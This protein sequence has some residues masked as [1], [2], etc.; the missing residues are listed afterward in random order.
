[1]VY[2]V[3]LLIMFCHSYVQ[4]FS[5]STGR[6]SPVWAIIDNLKKGFSFHVTKPFLI[7]ETRYYQAT[8]LGLPI[9]ISKYY[10]TVNGFTMNRKEL[11][12]LN[13]CICAPY[14]NTYQP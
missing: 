9:E 13:D 2:A 5:P 10:E 14:T 7:F 4:A 6:D 11:V 8:T 12:R 1:M 3:V